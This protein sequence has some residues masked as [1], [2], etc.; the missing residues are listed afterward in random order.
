M[1]SGTDRPQASAWCIRRYL[2]IRFGDALN[3]VTEV[4]GWRIHRSH[5]VAESGISQMKRSKGQT[6]VVLDDGAQLPV[7]RTYLSHLQQAGVT[8]AFLP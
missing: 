8:Q 1:L 6:V 7:S 4:K 5:W 2:L 3:E